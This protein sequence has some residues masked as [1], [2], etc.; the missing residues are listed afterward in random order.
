M[1]D[2]GDLLAGGNV[3]G[4]WRVGETV[5]RGTGPWTH[6]LHEAVATFTHDGPWRFFETRHPR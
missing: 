6:S 5:R 4:A 2:E 1:G 3:G